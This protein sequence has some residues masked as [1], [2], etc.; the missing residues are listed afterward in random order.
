MNINEIKELT[1]N[2]EKPS[3]LPISKKSVEIR[4]LRV[5]GQ[6]LCSAPHRLRFRTPTTYGE[7]HSKALGV[8]AFCV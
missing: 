8:P 4:G 6:L 1:V 3:K 5:K 7:R 2:N